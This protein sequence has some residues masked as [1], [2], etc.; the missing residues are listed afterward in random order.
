LKA[1]LSSG[2]AS[3]MK[4][5]HEHPLGMDR[6][7]FALVLMMAA[8]VGIAGLAAAF[9]LGHEGR[10]WLS[11]ATLGP[12]AAIGTVYALQ[13]GTLGDLVRATPLSTRPL[14]NPNGDEPTLGAQLISREALDKEVRE[15]ARQISEDYRGREPVLV[16]IMEGAIFFTHD[17]ADAIDT[18]TQLDWLKASSY[19]KGTTSSGHVRIVRDINLDIR[20]RDVLVIDDI[21]DTGRTLKTVTD[22]L[23]RRRPA[24]VSICVLMQKPSRLKF[25]VH[26]KYVGFPDIP[27]QFVVGYGLDYNDRFRTVDHIAILKHPSQ[28][29]PS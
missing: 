6:R 25:D 12:L 24:S 9:G 4:H 15:L 21:L 2:Y 28:H 10:L 26:A 16:G 17:L 23:W 5:E 22:R 11:A 3:R 13:L 14:A 27:D 29:E 1:W 19:G 18:P 7:L 8:G 20:D